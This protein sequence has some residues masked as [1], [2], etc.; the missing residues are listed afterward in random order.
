MGVGVKITNKNLAEP[1]SWRPKWHPV[2]MVESVGIG[3]LSVKTAARARKRR[4]ARRSR[5]AFA[6]RRFAGA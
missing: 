2:T 4:S 5:R 6:K 3:R 1:G